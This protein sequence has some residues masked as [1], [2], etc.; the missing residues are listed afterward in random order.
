[1]LGWLA[2]ADQMS[3]CDRNLNIVIFSDTV[4]MINVR[5]PNVVIFSD[6]INMINSDSA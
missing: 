5:N 1:M 3:V 2:V 6:T 4:N